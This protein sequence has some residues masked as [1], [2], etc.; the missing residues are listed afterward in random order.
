LSSQ[1]LKYQAM[2]YC[3]SYF[4]TRLLQSLNGTTTINLPMQNEY[5]V[6]LVDLT[7]LRLPE[8]LNRCLG[9]QRAY[10]D[11]YG[12]LIPWRSD[13]APTDVTQNLIADNLYTGSSTI[14]AIPAAESSYSN[15]NG[16]NAIVQKYKFKEMSMETR[17]VMSYQAKQGPSMLDITFLQD[18]VTLLTAGI[19]SR[20][21]LT[22]YD[23]NQS[24]NTAG[25]MTY[26]YGDRHFFNSKEYDQYNRI[27]CAGFITPG[28][29]QQN[30]VYDGVVTNGLTSNISDGSGTN[31]TSGSGTVF[32]GQGTDIIG[33]I[34]VRL[35]TTRPAQEIKSSQPTPTPLLAPYASNSPGHPVTPSLKDRINAHISPKWGN[36]CG[37]GYSA[38][39]DSLNFNPIMKDGRYLVEPT[40]REDAAC[41]RHD[42]GYYH[43][44]GDSAKLQEADR[45]FVEELDHLGSQGLLSAFGHM[46][47]AFFRPQQRDREL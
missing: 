31:H 38:G 19:H 27:D 13:V 33:G 28:N 45:K 44:R 2:W 42:E 24:Y 43:A 3:G 15:F 4:G 8:M 26:D 10:S 9:A 16:W 14:V 21:K 37:A 46:A 17:A 32:T 34:P 20:R 22:H 23:I 30:A 40:D 25:Y 7:C 35:G 1:L 36:Y 12:T 29:H 47:K 18:S 6:G 41:K 11:K 39:Q 5:H